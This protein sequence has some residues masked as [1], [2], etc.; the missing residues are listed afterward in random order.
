MCPFPKNPRDT[1]GV[2][3][4]FLL[5]NGSANS[6]LHESPRTESEDTETV[7]SRGESESFVDASR[8]VLPDEDVEVDIPGPRGAIFREALSSLD[9]LDPRVNFE[10]RASVMKSIPKCL[11]GPFKN[12][13]KSALE[14]AQQVMEFA[15]PG[16][17]SCWL[18][19]PECCFIAHQEGV[20]LRSQRWWHD[21]Y[22]FRKVSGDT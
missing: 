14:E 21:L 17:G 18:Y 13:L 2:V 1:S 5:T 15:L 11:R 6:P 4:V 9:R 10:K 22:R 19:F 16:A 20:R 7:D 12:V 8:V 3:G